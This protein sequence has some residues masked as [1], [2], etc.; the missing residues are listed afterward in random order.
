MNRPWLRNRDRILWTWLAGF[1]LN[2]RSVLVIVQPETV[3]RWQQQGFKLCWR[4]MS[5]SSKPGRPI[6]DAEIRNLIR[7]MSRHNPLWAIPRIQSE[8]RSLGYEASKATVD[9]C[10]VGHRKSP[11]Q[12]SRTF[13]DNHVRDILAV[14]FFTAPTATCHILF[15]LV[16]RHDRRVAVHFNA[17]ANP[18]AQWTAQRIVEGFP[19]D[20]AP[21]FLIRDRDSIY[22]KFFRQRIKN[23]GIEEV[24]WAPRSP[25]QNP[26]VERLIGSIRRECLTHGIVFNERQLRR[27]L[28]DCFDYCHEARAHLSLDQNSPV[29]RE[30]APPDRGQLIAIPQVGGLHHRYCCTA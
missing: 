29:A 20:R 19:L 16:L 5:R 30:V 12:T 23:M 6:T 13:L 7:R 2:W 25:C 11:S 26:F 9:R 4:W 1:W 22:G 15:L 21:R 18:T 17:R 10:K 8:L 28:H 27:I 3:V 24:G 14:D